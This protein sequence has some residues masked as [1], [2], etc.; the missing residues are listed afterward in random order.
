MV[1]FGAAAAKVFY[2]VDKELTKLGRVYGAGISAATTDQ[3]T[4]IKQ[5]V[6]TLAGELSKS[7]G[8][9]A[10]EVAGLAADLLRRNNREIN[11]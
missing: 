8:I 1:A 3:I 11:F 6:I 5:Q 9:S 7:L 2:D 10:K 4:K